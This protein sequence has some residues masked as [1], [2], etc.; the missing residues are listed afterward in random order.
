LLEN[1]GIVFTFLLQRIEVILAEAESLVRVFE[2]LSC[3]FHVIIVDFV[4]L[5]ELLFQWVL[6]RVVKRVQLIPLTC[7]GLVSSMG[8]ARLP[9]LFASTALHLLAQILLS[10]QLTEIQAHVLLEHARSKPE[11][12]VR[13]TIIGKEQV[14]VQDELRPLHLSEFILQTWSISC[15]VI[16]GTRLLLFVLR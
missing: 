16:C 13:L 12:F 4:L 2:L 3:L 9:P 1:I 7:V 15:R 11:V 6:L 5:E 8:R 10:L 14:I